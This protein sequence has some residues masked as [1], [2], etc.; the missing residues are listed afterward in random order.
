MRAN[1]VV[2]RSPFQNYVHSQ[3]TIHIWVYQQTQK[4]STERHQESSVTCVFYHLMFTIW[5]NPDQLEMGEDIHECS[6]TNR[7]K[8]VQVVSVYLIIPWKCWPKIGIRMG[9]HLFQFLRRLFSDAWLW[10]I[11]LLFAKLKFYLHLFFFLF[12]A[13]DSLYWNNTN[14][15]ASTRV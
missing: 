8:H 10:S 5:S 4:D 12:T 14:L 3:K 6:A 1:S 11:Y 7:L 9:L 15:C 13:P 2:V